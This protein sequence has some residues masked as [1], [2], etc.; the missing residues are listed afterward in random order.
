MCLRNA[1]LPDTGQETGGNPGHL[2]LLS[3]GTLR[4][5]DFVLQEPA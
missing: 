2:L 5:G 4:A 1:M 3:D